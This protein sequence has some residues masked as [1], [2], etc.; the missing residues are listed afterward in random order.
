MDTYSFHILSEGPSK[1]K[2]V[3]RTYGLKQLGNHVCIPD[4]W[5]WAA[6]RSWLS[7]SPSFT[8]SLLL[9]LPISLTFSLPIDKY[10]L[11]I[12]WISGTI[13]YYVYSNEQDTHKMWPRGSLSSEKTVIKQVSTSVLN[14]P[15]EQKMGLWVSVPEESEL[16][17]KNQERIPFS[18]SIFPQSSYQTSIPI[19]GLGLMWIICWI[20]NFENY[21]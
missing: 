16:G 13:R 19:P 9:P 6:S 15:K 4:R 3:L 7:L 20:V 21:L 1:F 14:V 10:L 18:S 8:P 12:Y 17:G 5:E 11:S 2:A